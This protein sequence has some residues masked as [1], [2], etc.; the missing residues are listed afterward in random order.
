MDCGARIG[1]HGW[2]VAPGRTAETMA[3]DPFAAGHQSFLREMGIDPAFYDFTNTA[4]PAHDIHIM[5]AQEIESWG[6]LTTP[7]NCP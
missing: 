5:S 3:T 7:A 1:V 2:R 6:L 4:A